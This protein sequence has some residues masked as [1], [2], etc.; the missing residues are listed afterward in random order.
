MLWPQS[1]GSSGTDH[2]VEAPLG[3]KMHGPALFP[4]WK[5]L[6]C[7]AELYSVEITGA[8]GKVYLWGVLTPLPIDPSSLF[9][10]STSFGQVWELIQT[11]M[12][13]K[14]VN[15]SLS[16]SKPRGTSRTVEMQTNYAAS[17][18]EPLTRSDS[19]RQWFIRPRR[20]A[21]V[22]ICC[23]DNLVHFQIC[24]VKVNQIKLR[25]A[26]FQHFMP[27]E[28]ESSGLSWCESLTF[29]WKCFK[30]SPK[31][32]CQYSWTYWCH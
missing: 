10:W 17:Q 8:F 27:Q 20:A 23:H 29:T 5:L 24:N 25:C 11:L 12:R 9:H 30:H 32:Q 31:L 19:A 21:V 7:S 1:P 16:V 6:I 15:S 13:T 18:S 22:I 28:T 26:V 2:A 3:V 14:E 4:D